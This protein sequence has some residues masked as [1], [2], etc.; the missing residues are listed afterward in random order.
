[1]GIKRAVGVG[2]LVVLV[3]LAFLLSRTRTKFT[4]PND[5][6]TQVE[7]IEGTAMWIRAKLDTN[8]TMT[9][10]EMLAERNRVLKA[11]NCPDSKWLS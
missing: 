6:K 11:N 8:P 7:Y 2:M 5:Y 3:T 1:M 10:E 4:C 9:L